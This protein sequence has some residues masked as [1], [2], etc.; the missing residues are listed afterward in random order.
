MDKFNLG[1]AMQN[2]PMGQ[3]QGG[4]PMQAMRGQLDGYIAQAIDHM[5]TMVPGGEKFA[6]QAK[7]A[8][9]SALDTLQRQLEQEASRRMGGTQPS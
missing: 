2:I 3:Q 8:I 1:D 7:Q 9:S 5:A 4:N 6:P